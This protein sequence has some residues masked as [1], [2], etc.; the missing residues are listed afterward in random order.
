MKLN[1]VS[2]D[3]IKLMLSPFSLRDKAKSWLTYFPRGSIT[4]WEVLVQKFFNRYFPQSKAAKLRGEVTSFKQHDG[5]SLSEAWE[6][7]NENLRKCSEPYFDFWTQVHTFYHGILPH[8]RVLVDAAAGSA[9]SYKTLEEAWEEFEM[10]AHNDYQRQG[11]Q[12][13]VKKGYMEEDTL[14][15]LLAHSKILTRQLTDLTKKVE[16]L[17]VNAMSFPPMVCDF[18]GGDHGSG[19]CLENMFSNPQE[20]V[21]YMGNP[22]RPQNNPYSNAYNLGWRNHPNF[23]W[24]NQAQQGQQRPPFSHQGS[25]HQP[26]HQGTSSLVASIQQKPW[27]IVVEKLA[28]HTSSLMEETRRQKPT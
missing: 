13:V 23:S 22:P 27:E 1:E 8:T 4:T 17:S 20:Q 24:S 11:E 5:E 12:A 10:M 28:T 7:Y 19:D 3:A 16:A 9:L 26:P 21:N 14:D 15:A 18:C 25:S 6:R 2:E